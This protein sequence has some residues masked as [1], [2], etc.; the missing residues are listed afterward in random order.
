MITGF[1]VEK[2]LF[3]NPRR[4]VLAFG[5][6]KPM[7]PADLVKIRIAGRLGRKVIFEFLCC[8][9]IVN[10][11]VIIHLYVNLSQADMPICKA[12]GRMPE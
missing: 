4:I 2:K 7:G 10:H 1:A 9:W 5:T 8:L 11:K 6:A 12:G 3:G